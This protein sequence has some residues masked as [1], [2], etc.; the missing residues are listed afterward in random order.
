MSAGRIAIAACIALPHVCSAFAAPNHGDSRISAAAPEGTTQRSS[1]H[2][3][4]P[5]TIAPKAARKTHRKART[6]RHT[7]VFY[8][9]STE[10]L[11]LGGIDPA[12]IGKVG[13]VRGVGSKRTSEN[14]ASARQ[15]P[16]ASGERS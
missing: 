2:T 10:Q 3:A 16:R 14:A 12:Q 1:V 4:K 7:D 8:R 13:D 9:W 5:H 15:K 11:M 6:P